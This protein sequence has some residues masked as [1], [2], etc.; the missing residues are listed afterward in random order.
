MLDFFTAATAKWPVW[1]PVPRQYRE[2][3]AAC[4]SRVHGEELLDRAMGALSGGQ[5]QQ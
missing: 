4:L 1:L 2:R 5:L 3:A